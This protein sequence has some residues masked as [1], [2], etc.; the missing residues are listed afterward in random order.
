MPYI[1]STCSMDI[2]F[3]VREKVGDANVL[4]K[5]IHILGG[6]NCPNEV[7]VTPKGVVSLI[8][9]D[10]LA[11]LEKHHYFKK[12]VKWGHFTVEN[13]SE[14]PDKVAADMKP[15]DGYAPLTPESLENTDIE[16]VDAA[17]KGKKGKGKSKK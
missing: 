16:D 13:K 5:T 12:K 8:T 11:Y 7:L 1:Y 17:S 3:P 15:K 6:A 2:D 9:D 4:R 14:D 10:D